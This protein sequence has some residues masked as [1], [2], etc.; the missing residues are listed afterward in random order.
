MI[1]SLICLPPYLSIVSNV[2]WLGGEGRTKCC[3]IMKKT[4]KSAAKSL[5]EVKWT[6]NVPK[7]PWWG[8]VFERMVHSIKRCLRKIIGQAKLSFDELLTA[9]TEVEMVINSRPLSYISTDDLEEP[10]T[11]SHLIVGRRLMS[12][13]HC[14][15]CDLDDDDELFELNPNTLTRR[16]R[17]LNRTIDRF[18][19]RWRREYLVELREAHRQ[20]G[21]GSR[22]PRIAKGDIV[23]IHDEGQLQGMWSLGVVE[24][25]LIGNDSEVR[26]AVL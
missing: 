17:H 25:V 14:L 5:R 13:P 6:L 20:C 16:A 23:I 4:F 19:E 15:G 12:T 3:L 11:P 26:A 10:L 2:L 22:A 18:W 1:L 7:A 8:G 9:I 24:E 21:N